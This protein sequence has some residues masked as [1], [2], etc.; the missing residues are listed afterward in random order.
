MFDEKGEIVP[1]HKKLD[2]KLCHNYRGTTF[3]VTVIKFMKEF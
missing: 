1:I 3:S 2:K